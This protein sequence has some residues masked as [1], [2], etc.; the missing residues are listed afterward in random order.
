LLGIA[1]P[2]VVIRRYLTQL[3]F[4]VRGNGQ[5]LSV[6]VPYWRDGDVVAAEDII[7]EIARLHGYDKFSSLVPTPDVMTRADGQ[8]FQREHA[9]KQSLV[10]LGYT[11]IY[12]YALVS[13]ALVRAA[14]EQPLHALAV[15]NPLNSDLTYLR[16]NLLPSLLTVLERNAAFSASL[17]LFEMAKIYL[18]GS[19]K[20]GID[21]YR[22]ESLRCAAVLVDTARSPQELFQE[23]KGVLESL[24]HE[25]GL[26]LEDA[27]WQ[28]G[29]PD[30]FLG[31]RSVTLRI[32]D[33]TVGSVGILDSAFTK[34]VGLSGTVAAVD[35]DATFL[36]AT[37]ARRPYQAIAK[38]PVVK[39]DI[40][41]VVPQNVR[42]TDVVAAM[43]KASPLLVSI[44]LFDTYTGLQIGE[45]MTSYSLHL[46]F[47]AAD[48]TLSVDEV[49]GA[50]SALE[51]ALSN[52][53]VTIRS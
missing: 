27:Q 52:S 46:T 53:N 19:G 35:A 43:Q 15:A 4:T 31:S 49:A 28:N 41:L 36:S 51:T 47:R 45:G 20:K 17:R 50:W 48:R 18:P 1:L 39:R 10:A 21:A 6:T 32:A 42:Y 23:A 16:P 34:I 7:E 30:P 38:F 8:V 44:D 29:A 3:G 9:L 14:G 5:V 33:R 12:S 11:E 37:V 25:A 24:V 13:E 2:I 26:P 40:S 22:T